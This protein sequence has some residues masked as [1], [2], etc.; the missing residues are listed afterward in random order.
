M[1]LAFIASLGFKQLHSL[2]YV[3]DNLSLHTYHELTH[4]VE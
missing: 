2:K 4:G 1:E 3:S